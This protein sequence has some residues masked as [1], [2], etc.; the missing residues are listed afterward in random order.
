MALDQWPF[1]MLEENISII[2]EMVEEEEKERKGQEEYQ[3]QSMPNFNPS[4]YMNQMNSMAGK[5]KK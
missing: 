1:W 4:Q 5:F 2:N 3:G